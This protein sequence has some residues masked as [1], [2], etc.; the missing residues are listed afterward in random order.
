MYKKPEEAFILPNIEQ[1]NE[2]SK[3]LIK[4]LFGLKPKFKK[5]FR[6][7]NKKKCLKG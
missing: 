7:K 5:N 1:K 3:I 6:K 4:K 2:D